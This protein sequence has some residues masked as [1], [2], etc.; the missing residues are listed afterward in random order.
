[1]AFD[2]G[3]LLQQYIGGAVANNGK[4][5]DDFDQVAQN[6]PRAS[7]AQGIASALRSDQTPP[8]PQMVSQLFGQSNPDQRA[9]MLNNLIGGAGGGLLSSV[10]GGALGKIFGGNT[11][12]VTPEQAAQVSPEQVQELAEKAQQQNPGIVDRMS[13]FYAEHPTLI[14][15]AGGA[16]LA[17]A[18][19]YMANNIRKQS[20]EKEGPVGILSNIFHKIFPG[21][22]DAAPAAT[23]AAPAA[24]PAAPSAAPQPQAAPAPGAPAAAPAASAAPAAA[25][26]QQVDVEQI[27]ND[28]QKSSGQQLNW[29]TS[30]V[31]LLKLLGLDS[32]L[33]SRKELAA[34]LNYTGDTGDS[35]KMNIWLHRQVMNKLAA[36]GGKVPADL[37]D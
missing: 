3:N 18:L 13:D 29:R 1:M 22:K 16:A 31:D 15:A 4:A 7:I 33:Q 27:L 32:S 30:I 21:K 14:K 10:A 6:A 23:T 2:L 28:M 11:S 19:G 36:N 26:M 8:F 5:A 34:E 12:Q 20:P 17:V 24:A 35:A 25:P 37:R 9:G